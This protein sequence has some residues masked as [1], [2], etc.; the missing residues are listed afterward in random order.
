MNPKIVDSVVGMVA[1]FLGVVTS[2]QEQFEYWLRISS[3]L[4]GIAVGLVSFYRIVYKRNK[5]N[6]CNKCN[7][8]KKDEL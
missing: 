2:L 1:P 5:R 6:K 4:V 7:K 3:L 8:G